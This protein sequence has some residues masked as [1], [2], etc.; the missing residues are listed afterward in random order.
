MKP[1]Q[2][3]INRAISSAINDRVISEVQDMMGNLPLD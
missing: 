1:V 2:T 3:Q